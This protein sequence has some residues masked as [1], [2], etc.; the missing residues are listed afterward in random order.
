M[1]KLIKLFYNDNVKI[2]PDSDPNIESLRKDPSLYDRITNEFTLLRYSLSTI[3]KA[4]RYRGSEDIHDVLD[5]IFQKEKDT[6]S[7]GNYSGIVSLFDETQQAANMNSLDVSS[8]T[9]IFGKKGKI[10]DEEYEFVCIML[11]QM[12]AV[13][14]GISKMDQTFSLRISECNNSI[15]PKMQE[16]ANYF[17]D[18]MEICC[19]AWIDKSVALLSKHL[20]LTE[21]K[22][23]DTMYKTNMEFESTE[24]SLLSPDISN[25]VDIFK[26][27][28]R[29]EL[30][31][32][33]MDTLFFNVILWILLDPRSQRR[34]YRLW[35]T[36][37]KTEDS[38]QIHYA[39][40]FEEDLLICKSMFIDEFGISED[41]FTENVK[42]LNECNELM[43]LTTLN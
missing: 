13:M 14:M 26:K 20:F 10:S 29:D 5:C 31:E 32:K 27:F 7:S 12:D 8:N 36:N 35:I 15:Q 25:Y 28:V 16:L 22:M 3:E 17:V 42:Q 41:D 40:K 2:F 18:T 39:T 37:K 9:H 19:E 30:H 33:I 38:E 21:F 1:I 34:Y 6:L 43:H 4:M 11:A 23:K 24:R